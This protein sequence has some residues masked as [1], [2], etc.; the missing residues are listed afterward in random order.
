MIINRQ[1]NQGYRYNQ[2]RGMSAECSSDRAR[3][4]DVLSLAF[5]HLDVKINESQYLQKEKRF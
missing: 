4:N 2:A 3:I 1:Q 5:V